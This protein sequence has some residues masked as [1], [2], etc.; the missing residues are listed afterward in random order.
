LFYGGV[1]TY[2]YHVL[3]D[4]SIVLYLL[5][6]VFLSIAGVSRSNVGTLESSLGGEWLLGFGMVAIAPLLSE[7]ML[8]FGWSDGLF[9]V[10]RMFL[11]SSLFFMFQN[12]MTASAVSASIRTGKA[13]YIATG[14]PTAF[15]HYDLKSAYILYVESHYY[16][17]L[18]NFLLWIL[19][20]QFLDDNGGVVPM[21]LVLFTTITWLIAPVL[22][23]PQV[24]SWYY[25]RLDVSVFRSFVF[26]LRGLKND[27]TIK[28]N[29]SLDKMWREK[30]RQ[31]QDRDIV[32]TRLIYL[33]GAIIALLCL[34]MVAFST[35]IDY[36]FVYFYIWVIHLLMTMTWIFTNYANAVSG[37]WMVFPILAYIF[38][39]L[40]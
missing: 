34:L 18:T 39:S 35:M 4:Y 23:C 26:L 33:S 16:P 22:Y 3:V 25:F 2:I 6:F 9:S 30:E 37:L 27:N 29:T 8:E 32:G 40:I 7:Y 19:Y 15:D 17:A 20:R 11:P 10:A 1:G 13:I 21:V 12:K 28:E 36:L 31:N 14:R 24:G 38:F 5:T